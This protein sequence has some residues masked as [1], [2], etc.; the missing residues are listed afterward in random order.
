MASI[1][2]IFCALC[3]FSLATFIHLKKKQPKPLVCP[4]GHTCDPVV[5]GDY[6]RFMCIPVELLGILYYLIILVSYLAFT[7]NP[8]LQSRELTLALLCI[9][10]LAF[11]FSAYLTF[12]QA[13]ILKEW[14]TWCLISATLC[15][16]IFMSGLML[17][18]VV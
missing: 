16:V 17:A 18:G 15:M 10:G 7:M 9:S 4:I 2:T 1:L 12:V 11:L 3:G 5:R 14:C 13:F 6:S 8:L